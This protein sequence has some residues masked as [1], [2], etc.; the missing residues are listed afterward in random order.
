[1][2]SNN[3]LKFLVFVPIITWHNEQTSPISSN[4]CAFSPTSLP[5]RPPIHSWL[6]CVVAKWQPP[7]AKAPS[8]SSWWAF[9]TARLLLLRPPCL[10]AAAAAASLPGCCCY[11]CCCYLARLLPLLLQLL[12][13]CP[14]AVAAAASSLDCCGCCCCLQYRAHDIAF[15]ELV[16]WSVWYRKKF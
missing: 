11:C 4:P 9:I 12:P 16:R 8:I 1:M 10:A 13:P 6:L 15:G 5:L 2:P 14:T 7:K 3:I